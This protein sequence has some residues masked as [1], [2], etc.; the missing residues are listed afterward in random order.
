MS[1]KRFKRKLLNRNTQWCLVW[2]IR[3]QTEK[4]NKKEKI[5]HQNTLKKIRYSVALVSQIT[6][7]VPAG[8]NFNIDVM[9]KSIVKNFILLL[10]F[11]AMKIITDENRIAFWHRFAAYAFPVSLCS[12][13]NVCIAYLKCFNINR[14]VVSMV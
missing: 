3:H 8:T 5:P 7:L 10:A 6:F 2:I 14:C 1:R 9:L 11:F 13:F 12:W 4:V